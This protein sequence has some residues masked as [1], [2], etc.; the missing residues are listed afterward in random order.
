MLEN[1][2]NNFWQSK[3]F[4]TSWIINSDDLEKS[5][6]E[7]K[8]FA[9]KIIGN[10]SLPI[11]NN[12]DFYCLNREGTKSITIEQVRKLQDFLYNSSGFGDYKFAVIIEADLMNE[13]AANCCLKVLEEAPRNSFLFL[14]PNNASKLLPTIKSRCHKLSVRYGFSEQK[15]ESYDEFLYMINEND[16][17]K[18]I[19]YLQGI[20]TKANIDEWNNFCQNISRFILNISKANLGFSNNLTDSEKQYFADNQNRKIDIEKI[21]KMVS[22]TNKFDLDKRHMGLLILECL[23]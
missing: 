12:P 17:N 8:N 4:A 19:K 22:D 13:F 7:I 6:E 1:K 3:K 18:N 10:E 15:N 2:L 23:S 21:Y 11:D 9:Q 5:L 16:I 14:L 20:S